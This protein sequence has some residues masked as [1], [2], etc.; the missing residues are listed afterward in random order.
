MMIL[1]I[2]FAM[3]VLCILVVLVMVLVFG[4]FMFVIVG[5]ICCLFGYWIILPCVGLLIYLCNLKV[6]IGVLSS[7]LLEV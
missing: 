7:V 1:G 3:I 4:F 5:L 2:C 6:Y